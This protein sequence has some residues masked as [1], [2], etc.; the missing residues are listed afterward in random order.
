MAFTEQHLREQEKQLESLKDELSRL[1]ARFDGMCKDGGISGADL[2]KALAE[3]R[4]PEMESA[5][6][7]AREEAERAGKARAAQHGAARDAAAGKAVSRGR[8]GAVRV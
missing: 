1:N 5:L 4:S 3:K 8:P 7:R 2:E 6:S